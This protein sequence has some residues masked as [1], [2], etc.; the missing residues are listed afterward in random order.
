MV[1]RYICHSKK[2]AGTAVSCIRESMD[3]LIGYGA[4]NLLRF[5][6][7]ALWLNERAMTELRFHLG[8][9][10]AQHKKRKEKDQV[11]VC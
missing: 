2:R 6:L 4:F 7:S 8:L 9:K 1:T 5:S 3:V 11:S 10:L